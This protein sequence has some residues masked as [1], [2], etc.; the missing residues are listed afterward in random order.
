MLRV[1]YPRYGPSWAGWD[2]VLAG[3]SRDQI[4]KAASRRHIVFE[5]KSN[6]Q[7]EVETMGLPAVDAS[8]CVVS[9]LLAHGMTP[10]EID[11]REKW[12]PGTAE[13]IAVCAWKRG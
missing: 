7:V 1:Y 10:S 8:E 13:K 12:F 4:R 3:R 5:D 11:K 2:E 6:P 9:T